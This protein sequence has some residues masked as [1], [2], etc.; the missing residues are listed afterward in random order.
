M[1]GL[2]ARSEPGELGTPGGPGYV[3]ETNYQ[4]QPRE[5]LE[6]KVGQGVLGDCCIAP[7]HTATGADR[8]VLVVDT[9][10]LAHVTGRD[11]ANIGQ[12]ITLDAPMVTATWC[13]GDLVAFVPSDRDVTDDVPDSAP[14]VRV[15]SARKPCPKNDTAHGANTQRT[16]MTTGLSG[17]FARVVRDGR[18]Q[19]GAV[20]RI[21]ERPNPTWTAARVHVLLYGPQPCQDSATLRQM[22]ALAWLEEPRYRSRAVAMAE[23]LE[24]RQ[25]LQTAALAG[26]VL[27][28]AVAGVYL[29]RMRR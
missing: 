11:D 4:R 8:D 2:A 1:I 27:V 24:R 10:V 20:V 26:A 28:A 19:P 14:L 22:A 21:L 15:T 18:I 29:W 16:M 25:R 3:A 7:T 12:N 17:V 23:T 5:V 13:I 6:L 9:G